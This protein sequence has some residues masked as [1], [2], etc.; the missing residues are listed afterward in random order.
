[1]DPSGGRGVAP[2]RWPINQSPRI[3]GYAGGITPE[4]CRAVLDQ[5]GE[6][7]QQG[8]WLDMES[9]VRTDDWLDLDKCT[10]VLEQ[11]GRRR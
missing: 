4:N 5:V 1:Y 7:S 9:G 6:L 11:V 3:V 2:T 10:S 8:F